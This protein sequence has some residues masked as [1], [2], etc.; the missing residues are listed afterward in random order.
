MNLKAS[1]SHILALGLLLGL[2]ACANRNTPSDV[3]VLPDINTH[4]PEKTIRDQSKVPD[5]SN[6][7]AKQTE[8]TVTYEAVDVIERIRQGFKFPKLKSEHIRQYEK[9]ST[10]H[11][12]YLEGLFAR[13]TPFLYH[14]VEEIE[15]RGLPMELAL[16]PAIESAYKPDAVSRS[17]AGGLWQFIPST[18]RHFGLRQDWWYDG[19]RDALLSTNAALDYLTQLNK[20]FDGDW[21]L[22]LAAYN[23]GQGTVARAIRT[24]KRKGR[25]TSYQNLPLRLETRRYIP[26]LIA[27]KNVINNP[28]AYGVTLPFIESKPYFKVVELPGQ[29]DLK[30]FAKDAGID[31]AELRHL[32]AG[33]KRWATSPEGPHRL[34]IP[35]NTDGDIEHAVAAAQ[36]AVKIDYSNHKVL[37][38][39]SLSSIAHRYGV[40]VSAL[41]SSN[42]LSS[43]TIRAGKN[44]MVPL[45]AS[46]VSQMAD[47]TNST[48]RESRERESAENHRVVHHVRRGDTL[49]S[50]AKKYK[51]QVNN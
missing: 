38:G 47:A 15:T 16:L 6:T 44:L 45:S 19:R 3:V 4:T 36:R 37:P 41:Q 9:W 33:F 46:R 32:N 25:G 22:T 7:E 10:E 17:N 28:D 50:I 40:S 11:D 2:S 14:I 43:T 51:V 13:G 30:K 39:E 20:R 5:S 21:F 29:I 48:K 12:S 34:L 35:I 26:K 18:G 1:F 31:P 27:L 23:A 42:N 49:W 24:N 8:Q